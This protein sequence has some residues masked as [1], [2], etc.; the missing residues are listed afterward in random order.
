MR[1]PILALT[2][3][4][5]ALLYSLSTTA[6]ENI[7][8]QS[9]I[10]D[11]FTSIEKTGQKR[12]NRAPDDELKERMTEFEIICPWQVEID[13]NNDRKRDWVGLV[14]K[15]GQTILLAYISSLKGYR[16]Y[17]VKQYRGFPRETHFDYMPT[18]EAELL[19]K[20]KL[21][22]N[23]SPRFALIENRIGRPSII[24][25]WNGKAMARFGEF[26]GNY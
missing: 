5:S 8:C 23:T 3:I 13:L 10:F 18:K 21:S 15:Q 7:Q 6:E 26:K 1:L 4:V 9:K 25:I 16:S 14:T 22:Q 24:Y 2:L 19:S 20:K 12:P 11:R 17:T